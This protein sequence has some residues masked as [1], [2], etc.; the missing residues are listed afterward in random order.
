M[1][2]WLKDAGE[3]AVRT[4]AQGWLGVVI[5]NGIAPTDVLDA[6]LWIAGPS[7]GAAAALV[8][9]LFSVAGLGTDKGS[10]AG[11]VALPMARTASGHIPGEQHP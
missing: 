6:Q 7:A 11:L 4:F 10:P 2:S 1:N 8:S 3:R 9:V 5:V